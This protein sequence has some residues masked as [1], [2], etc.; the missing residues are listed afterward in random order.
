MQNN[1]KQQKEMS[2]EDKVICNLAGKIGS[3]ETNLVIIQERYIVL[4]EE[5]N[6][7]QKK[8]NKLQEDFEKINRE[9]EK[10]LSKS[11]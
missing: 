5:Y 10:L 8:Y 7:L 6:E 3:L 4:Q 2:F 11:R 9:Y 1:N